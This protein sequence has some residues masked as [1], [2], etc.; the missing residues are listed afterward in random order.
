MWPLNITFLLTE[1]ERIKM[2]TLAAVLTVM[3]TA[4]INRLLSSDCDS[5]CNLYHTTEQTHF[6]VLSGM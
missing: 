4:K 1:Q 2:C 6:K 5:M 3:K